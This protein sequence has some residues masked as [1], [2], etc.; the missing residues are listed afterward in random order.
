M[1][2]LLQCQTEAICAACWIRLGGLGMTYVHGAS[3]TL[4]SVSIR[5]TYVVLMRFG[6]PL[7]LTSASGGF[8]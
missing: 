8:C 2:E 7:N 4:V 1:H 6:F 5:V 3:T